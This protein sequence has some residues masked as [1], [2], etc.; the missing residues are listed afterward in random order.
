[1]RRSVLRAFVSFVAGIAGMSIA[2]FAPAI[3]RYEGKRRA[4]TR[5]RPMPASPSPYTCPRCKQP[6]SERFYGPC[7]SCRAEL[8]ATMSGEARHVERPDFE[9]RAHVVANHV[10]TKD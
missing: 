9:P 3:G 7:G 6:A 1:M 2:R 5:V 10:A 4:S 8:V